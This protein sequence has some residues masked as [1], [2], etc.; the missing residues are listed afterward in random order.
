MACWLLLRATP[1]SFNFDLLLK[2][3]KG[4]MVKGQ[5]WRLRFTPP[6]ILFVKNVTILF[7]MARIILHYSA[8]FLHFFSLSSQPRPGPT[9][10]LLR[11]RPF[12][13]LAEKLNLP[14]RAIETTDFALVLHC[15]A[16]FRSFLCVPAHT[17][18]H[19]PCTL[20]F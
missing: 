4:A 18:S 6:Q 19:Y 15:F 13:N 8:L 9:L 2:E 11:Q 20:L 10:L 3:Y 16:L 1:R 12:A 17:I 5:R 7:F 14:S